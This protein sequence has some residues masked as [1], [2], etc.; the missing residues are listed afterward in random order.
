MADRDHTHTT[1][2]DTT[3]HTPPTHTTTAGDRAYARDPRDPRATT[4]TTQTK[5]RRGTSWIGAIVALLAILVLAAWLVGGFDGAEETAMMVGDPV[6]EAPVDVV[7]PEAE[8]VIVA[9]VEGETV[10]PVADPVVPAQPVQ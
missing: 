8:A 5:K 9:P 4:T 7:E 2:T 10:A 6:V 1:T 3:G